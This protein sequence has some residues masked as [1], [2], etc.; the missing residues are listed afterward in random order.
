MS[1]FLIIL[2]LDNSL[3]YWR[4]ENNHY[5]VIAQVFNI[6]KYTNCLQLYYLPI[7][8]EAWGYFKILIFN[9]NNFTC[10]MPLT[11]QIHFLCSVPFRNGDNTMMR[12]ILGHQKRKTVEHLQKNRKFC[13]LAPLLMMHFGNYFSI[14]GDYQNMELLYIIWLIQLWKFYFQQII[15]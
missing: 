7:I 13:K 10:F 11:F 6:S 2:P 4:Y 12:V 15:L 5:A 1:V 14:H 3:C 8:I 9:V